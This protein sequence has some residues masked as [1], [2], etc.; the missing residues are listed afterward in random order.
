MLLSSS[1]LFWTYFT[2][3]TPMDEVPAT[4]LH[5]VSLKL[6]LLWPEDPALF[7]LSTNNGLITNYVAASLLPEIS[8]EVPED[9][10]YDTLKT[11]LISC[12]SLNQSQRVQKDL[13][14][15]QLLRQI[16]QLANKNCNG[17]IILQVIFISDLPSS[18]QII[19][20]SHPEI[21]IQEMASLA[22]ILQMPS[23]HH[24]FWRYLPLLKPS[25]L[26]G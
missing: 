6:P 15:I 26:S 11:C 13:R 25:L 20:R 5:A 17:D 21:T 7:F 3:S 24:Q 2:F 12:T 9:N 19:L 22:Y 4:I 16:E 10:P 14:P 18:I 1:H 23:L 8:R